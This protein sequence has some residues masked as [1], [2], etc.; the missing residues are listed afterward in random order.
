MSYLKK[1]QYPPRIIPII[2]HKGMMFKPVARFKTK[3]QVKKYLAK[4]KKAHDYHYRVRKHKH[5]GY[6]IYI[7]PT[8][9]LR[10]GGIR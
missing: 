3:R 2:R 6:T 9:K 4:D 8:V 7:S 5:H 10:H 1:K